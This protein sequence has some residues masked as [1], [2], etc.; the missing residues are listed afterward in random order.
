LR[1]DSTR[2]SGNVSGVW[3]VGKLAFLCGW[4]DVL[5]QSGWQLNDKVAGDLSKSPDRNLKRRSLFVVNSG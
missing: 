2:T 1:D 5:N 4:F 3:E